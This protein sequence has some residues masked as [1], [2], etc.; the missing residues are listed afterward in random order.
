[1]RAPRWARRRA[2]RG[3]IGIRAGGNR[4]VVLTIAANTN[5]YNVFTAAGSPTDPVD[6]FLTINAG[7][8]VSEATPANGAIFTTASFKAGST[9]KIVSLA[10]IAGGG[11]VGGAGGNWNDGSLAVVSGS[12]GGTAIDCQIPLVIDNTSGNVFGGGGGGGGGEAAGSANAPPSSSTAAGGGGGGGG[13][14]Y[15][16][17]T[18][19]VGGSAHPNVNNASD[20][21]NGTAGSSAAAGSGGAG[22]IV[23]TDP[24]AG[25]GGSGGDWGAAGS[26]GSVKLA[27]AFGN[28]TG[29]GGAAGNAVNMHG[30]SITWLGGNNGAQ[31]KGAVA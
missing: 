26:A 10:T 27:G 20:G 7:V 25:A 23:F 5:D 13:R 19:G 24:K 6:V 12:A 3:F 9:M 17:A 30:K 29:A 2:Q 31:V 14:G 21:S 4:I 18:F 11:G 22:G 16:N 8:V 1:M 28:G 15:N